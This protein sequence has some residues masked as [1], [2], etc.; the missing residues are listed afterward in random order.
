MKKTKQLNASQVLAIKNS[1][2]EEGQKAADA[3]VEA[4]N[5]MGGEETEYSLEDL[6][7]RLNE[8]VDA[9]KSASE[10]LTEEQQEIVENMISL[11]LKNIS[12]VASKKN[13]SKEVKNEV[14]K[15]IMDGAKSGNELR[16]SIHAISIKN[17][18]SGLTFED[19]IDYDL[20]DKF[21]AE[22]W[23]FDRLHKTEF[24]KFFYSTA[25]MQ[26][27]TAIAKGWLKT[28]DGQKAI[29]QLSETGKKLDPQYV[30]KIQQ[31]ALEDLARIRKAGKEDTIIGYVTNELRRVVVN[32]I[33][34][35]ILV[36][37]TVNQAG[38]RVTS[39]EAIGAKNATDA[40][41]I[42]ANLAGAEPSVAE[43]RALA[44]QLHN[45]FGYE[46]VAV[47]NASTKTTLAGYTYAAGGDVYFRT[48]AELAG[49]L[50]VDAIYTSNLVPEGGVILLIPEEYW[51]LEDDEIDVTYP[52]YE[53]NVVNWQYER[54]TAG[55]IHGLAS[56]AVLKPA[57]GSSSH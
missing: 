48:E 20:Q 1:F 9:L 23:L 27:A 5:A 8:L 14:I 12:N 33:V 17:G 11:K 16:D 30:Y 24:N 56:T 42:V 22:N 13:V 51:V 6:Q 53:L 44:D 38:E 57:G 55:A 49:Q 31:M 4:I 7:V 10:E 2:S 52:K 41:T 37:D 32:T 46:K 3:I 50:G 35:A 18:I 25:D 39:F 15:A 28:N 54:L 47:M 36:G 43:V 34:M 21:G 26:T 40:F 29:Q 19:V 45:P